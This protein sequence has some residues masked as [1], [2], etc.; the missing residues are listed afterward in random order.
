[1][2]ADDY[3]LDCQRY[4]ELNPVGAG[5]V[6]AP[7]DY[8]RSSRLLMDSMLPYGECRLGY[9]PVRPSGNR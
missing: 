9:E 4:I 7:D 6:A 8:V 2:D 3:L 5:L 1:M